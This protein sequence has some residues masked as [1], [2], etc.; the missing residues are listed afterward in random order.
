MIRIC[1]VSQLLHTMK[2]PLSIKILIPCLVLT[3]GVALFYGLKSNRLSNQLTEHVASQQKAQQEMDEYRSLISVDS[4]LVAGE[5]EDALN[6]SKEKFVETKDW[7]NNANLRI[8]LAQKFMDLERNI[9]QVSQLNQP[10]ETVDSLPEDEATSSKE[11]RYVDSLRFALEKSKIRMTRLERRLSQK[12]LGQYLTFKSS[13]GSDK[14]EK[15]P[16][17]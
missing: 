9:T 12:S 16:C 6:A 15:C 3:A 10:Q 7:K 1:T 14:C 13:K 5:Y 2:Q 4:L 11:I 8:A 17:R